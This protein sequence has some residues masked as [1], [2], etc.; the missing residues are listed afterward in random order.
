MDSHMDQQDMPAPWGKSGIL[1]VL[2]LSCYYSGYL[3]G[4]LT[5]VLFCAL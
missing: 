4:Y 5:E 2:L 1:L 3:I